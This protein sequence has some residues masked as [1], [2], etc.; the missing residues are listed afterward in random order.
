[1]IITQGFLCNDFVCEGFVP[2]P[3]PVILPACQKSIIC[4]VGNVRE[5]IPMLYIKKAYLPAI[6]YC[7]QKLTSLIV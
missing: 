1:M 3:I 5:C 4:Q 6:T 7:Y 2:A